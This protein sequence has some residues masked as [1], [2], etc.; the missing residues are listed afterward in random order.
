[1]NKSF[2]TALLC[3][4]A[5]LAFAATK[6][7][8]NDPVVMTINGEDVSLSEFEYLFN[9]NNSQ[10]LQPISFDEY[11]NMFVDYKLK[12]ADAKA[13]GID[14]TQAFIKEFGKFRDELAAPYLS[15]SATSERLINEQYSRLG[16]ERLVSHIM[17]PPNKSEKDD[18]EARLDSIRDIILN[19]IE[20][21]EMMSRYSVDR[22][23]SVKNGLMGW[24]TANGSLPWQFEEAAYNTPI[25]EISPVINS[26]YGYHII[27]P[28]KERPQRG[29]VSARHILMLTR[30]KNQEEKELQKAKI[31]SIYN[32]VKADTS[33]FSELAIQFSEDPGS[34]RRG[35]DLGWFGSGRMVAEF[36]SVAFALPVGG[37][38]EP[39]LT[40]Y[41]YHII[42]KTGERPFE[43]EPIE[44]MRKNL[45]ARFEKDGR[46]QLPLDVTADKL[47]SEY[48]ASINPNLIQEIMAFFSDINITMADTTSLHNLYNSG[49]I[50][51]TINGE[52]KTLKNAMRRTPIRPDQP[53]F[54]TAQAI[55]KGAQKAMNLDLLAKGRDQLME[56]N[57]DFRNLVNEYRD[58]ILLFE[59]SNRNVWEKASQDKEGLDAYF[60]SH[61]ENYT[62]DKPHFKG[63]VFMATTDSVNNK[64]IERAKEIYPKS[65][66]F[67][68]FTSKM[69]K[70][71]GNN[72]RIER[73]VAAKGENSIIDYLGFNATKPSLPNPKYQ[74]VV[75]FQSE[76]IEQPQEASDVKGAVI[77]DYQ[78]ELEQLWLKQ[79]HNKYPVKINQKNLKKARH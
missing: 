15:D 48:R 4:S 65:E 76:I 31:D 47:A 9:K 11:V 43:L 63:I 26:G 58:G 23:S 34:A 40:N 55:E 32:I 38:S 67:E 18:N 8:S 60:E 70:F 62:W 39:F 17:L 3:G 30:D 57:A 59:I 72:L 37:I 68:D 29:E 21:F 24:I 36:D 74:S 52:E 20:T 27:R 45:E 12:V 5:A 77:T 19:G 75:S 79:L 64:A 28:E 54:V 56:T 7:K 69:K 61:R 6:G 25:G 71:F 73:V 14:T 33:Q 2:L 13:E 50:A 16:R 66:N 49:I 44:N 46:S 10:Q 42:Y 78:G 51:Y 41:G 1:M 22:N 35:G 53:T